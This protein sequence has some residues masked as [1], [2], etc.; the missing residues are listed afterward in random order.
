MDR[1]IFGSDF[2]FGEPARELAKV[3]KL[4]SGPSRE[5]VLGQNL[6]ALLGRNIER[7]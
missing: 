6:L 5:R 7:N 4:F 2:P 3:E 1:I